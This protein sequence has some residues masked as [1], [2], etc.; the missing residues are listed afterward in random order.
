MITEVTASVLEPIVIMKGEFDSGDVNL[1]SG[2]GEL[3]WDGDTYTG[4]GGMLGMREVQETQTLEAVNVDIQLSGIPSAYISIA[5]T[6]NYQNRPVTIWLGAINSSG[7]VIADPYKIYRGRMDILE[8]D[9]GAETATLTMHT[10]N[11]LIDLQRTKER[12]YTPDDQKA[13]FPNDT[14]LNY[15]SSLQDQAIVWGQA[16]PK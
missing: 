1:W 9:E 16:S 7:A 15:V 2:I 6:E 12:R 3:I 13:N 14:G 10:E 5:L 11:R 8:I 4:A